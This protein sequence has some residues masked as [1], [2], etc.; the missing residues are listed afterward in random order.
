M[1]ALQQT[2]L[3]SCKVS[4]PAETKF[5]PARRSK[6]QRFAKEGR[7]G[8]RGTGVGTGEVVALDKF[9]HNSRDLYFSINKTKF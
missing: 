6:Q 9:S 1:L 8:G 4:Q 7:G 5:S 2:D 3:L